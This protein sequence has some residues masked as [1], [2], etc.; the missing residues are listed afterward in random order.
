MFGLTISR[1]PDVFDV[2]YGKDRGEF[3]PLASPPGQVRR[4]LALTDPE[5]AP[6][7]DAS[8]PVIEYEALPNASYRFKLHDGEKFPGGFGPTYILETDYWTLR[9]RSAQLYRTNLYARGVIRRMVT[10]EINSGLEVECVPE[11]SI[12][13][14]SRGELDDWTEEVE[15]RFG[16]WASRPTACDAQEQKTF[17]QIQATVRLEALVVGDVLVTVQQDRRTGLPRIRLV[18]GGAVQTPIDA[19]PA[20]GNRIVHGVELDP[21]GRQVAYWVRQ[22]GEDPTLEDAFDYKRIPAF[23]ARTGRRLAWLVYGSDKRL[24]DVRG[25]PILSLALQ[26][27][28]DLDRYRDS[29][30]RKAVIN[31]LLAI[32]IKRSEDKKAS[33]GLSKGAVRKGTQTSV[34]TTGEERTYAIQEQIPGIA[35][36]TLQVGEEPVAFQSHIADEKIGDVEEVFL[37]GVA[38]SL[39]IPPEILRL[40]FSN[41][42]SSSQAAINEYKIYLHPVR[43]FFGASFC[44]P[45]YEDWFVGCQLRQRF[46]APGFLSAW[47]NPGE[48]ETVAAWLS[49]DW[50]GHIKPSVKMTDV[51]KAYQMMV[52]E[53]FITRE[54]ACRELNGSKYSRNVKR[55][56]V[57][58]A[59]LA[60]ALAPLGSQQTPDAT[61]F[62]DDGEPVEPD[63]DRE[64]DED[65]D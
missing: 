18:S 52:A 5:P 12:L 57:E 65:E 50:S 54:K 64:D 14:K 34:D 15:T 40:S 11:E 36:E 27:F 46:D 26:S 4:S 44:Q 33:R 51:V 62:G 10:N 17:G 3:E 63:P 47:R 16:L 45:L 55:L 38:W 59:Q 8:V 43:T 25:E 31:S 22:G 1:K 2:L 24:D 56:A 60:E 42:Y 19:T 21:Q 49:A 61:G 39:E 6:E 48:F 37:Q 29:V 32:F 41:N 13:G 23:G 30:L 28:R 7:P 35:L 58:N 20:K 53:G 9:A